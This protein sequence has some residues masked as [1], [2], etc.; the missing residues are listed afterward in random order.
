LCRSRLAQRDRLKKKSPHQGIKQSQMFTVVETSATS[1]RFR[2]VACPY[3]PYGKSICEIFDSA[4][5]ISQL[6]H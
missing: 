1:G 4:L 2:R 5:S 6:L 3:S